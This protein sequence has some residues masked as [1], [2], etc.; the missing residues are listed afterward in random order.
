MIKKVIRE[1]LLLEEVF[2]AQAFVYHGSYTKPDVLIP[3]LLKGEFKPGTG[4]GDV[5]G[6]G[7]YTVYDLESTQ[8]ESGGYGDYIYKLKINLYGFISFEPDITKLIYKKDMTPAEQAREAGLSDEI[9]AALEKFSKKPNAFKKFF[10][11]AIEMIVGKKPSSKDAWLASKEIR[12]KVKGLIFNSPIDGKVALIYDPKIVVPVSYKK[13][14]DD[15][16]K[17]I[18]K[19]SLKPS[20]RRSALDNW[21]ETNF[22][23]SDSF[24]INK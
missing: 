22:D 15:K 9:V 6:R 11:D 13:V 5:Y 16:W 21:E 8:T 1:M 20:L 3:V 14:I 2:G 24:V 4:G 18:D 23:D 10:N 19:N 7:L 17:K 12:G